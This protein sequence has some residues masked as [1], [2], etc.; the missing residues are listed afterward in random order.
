MPSLCLYESSILDIVPFKWNIRTFHLL[1]ICLPALLLYQTWVMFIGQEESQLAKIT[2]DSSKITVVQVHGLMSQ[3]NFSS[4]SYR[5][6]AMYSIFLQNCCLVP[7]VSSS[8]YKRLSRTSCSTLCGSPAAASQSRALR[9]HL[10]L[11]PWSKLKGW[12]YI[13]TYFS[14]FGYLKTSLKSW[15]RRPAEASS[16]H[17]AFPWFNISCLTSFCFDV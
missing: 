7:N 6:L 10:G 17:Q 5:Y 15:S 3:V 2:R 4:A 12:L 1:K 14:S 8:D 16:R 11:N 13:S 9:T